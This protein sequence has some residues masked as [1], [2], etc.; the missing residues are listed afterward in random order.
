MMET[1]RKSFELNDI[2]MFRTH[3]G[4]PKCHFGVIVGIGGMHTGYRVRFYNSTKQVFEPSMNIVGSEVE[5]IGPM[6]EG[7]E[8]DWE[9][10]LPSP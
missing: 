6:P 9:K 8:Y 7:V 1:E 2:V 3:I 10:G 5:W 4:V